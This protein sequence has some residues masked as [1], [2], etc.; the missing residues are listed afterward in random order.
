MYNLVYDAVKSVRPDA[1]IGGPYIGMGPGNIPNSVVSQWLNTKHGGELVVVDGGFD[2]T[3]ATTDFT[4]AKFYTDLAPGFGSS[5][6][7]EQLY[8]LA[9]QNGIPA[10]RRHMVMPIISMPL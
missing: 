7:E 6:M 9:G 1:I 2:S 3:D 5:Q 4:N 10:L 8:L